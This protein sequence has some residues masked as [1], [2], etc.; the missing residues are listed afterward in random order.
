MAKC[1]HGYDSQYCG[2]V[3]GA[4]RHDGPTDGHDEP[5]DDYRFMMTGGVYPS[6]ER[7][8]MIE[9]TVQEYTETYTADNADNA[10][11]AQARSY[12]KRKLEDYGYAKHPEPEPDPLSDFAY[13]KNCS[14]MSILGE[15][16]LC[17][18]CEELSDLNRSQVVMDG[19]KA[20]YLKARHDITINRRIFY[21]ML[22]LWCVLM[23]LIALQGWG[24]G[25]ITA[26]GVGAVCWALA[27]PGYVKSTN[28]Y[29]KQ[30][31]KV[32]EYHPELQNLAARATTGSTG[33]R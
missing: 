22:S 13:C 4:W 9:S 23:C 19:H 10:L 11:V 15:Y 27:T 6:E 25:L 30:A 32:L 5:S 33:P 20:E 28:V 26:G 12:F 14:T 17:S 29:K 7:S 18:Y 24:E 2:N 1:V 31:A 8:A 3:H 16:G 21:G